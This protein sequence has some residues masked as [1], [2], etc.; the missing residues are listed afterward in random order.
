M[1]NWCP[2]EDSNYLVPA[3]GDISVNGVAIHAFEGAAIRQE[4]WIIATNGR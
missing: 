3:R 1:K 2:G 4:G